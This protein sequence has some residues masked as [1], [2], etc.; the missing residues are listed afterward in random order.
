MPIILGSNIASLQAQRRLNQSSETLARG[1]ERLG[2][3]MRINRASDDA[4]GLA[5]VS[6]LRT[7]SRIF[8]QAIRNINDGISLIA[9]AQGALTQLSSIIQ[10]Q[11]EL[12]EQAANG[13]YSSTQRLALDRESDALVDEYN[14]I[15]KST[16][17][18]GQYILDGN[19]D[20][21]R[22]QHGTGIA[23]STQ[24][25]IGQSL[26]SIAGDG[27]F[28][29]VASF[30]T[31][32]SANLIGL[33]T[34]DVN[35]DGILDIVT[36]NVGADI[37]IFFGNGSGGFV[38]HTTFNESAGLGGYSI[39]LSDLNGDGHQ[40]IVTQG[41][42]SVI[43]YLG[44]GDGT[45]QG[46]I[47]SSGTNG[48]D[49]TISDINSDGK[50]DVISSGGS[51]SLGN[52]D[53]SFKAAYDLAFVASSEEI[54]VADLN[55]DGF[56]DLSVLNY[57]DNTVTNY[58]GRGD[59][60]FAAGR[61]IFAGTGPYGM[62]V[63]DLSGDGNI[64]LAISG[65]AGNSVKILLG[66]GDG[67][68][69]YGNTHTTNGATAITAGDFNGDGATDL[70]STQY[71]GGT[72]YLL[73]GN[74]DGSFKSPQLSSIGQW[75]Y[76]V[77]SN[78]INRDGIEDIIDWNFNS[79]LFN[80]ALGNP[81]P[82]GRR[83]NT[84]E[85]LDLRTTAGARAA[86]DST[87]SMLEKISLEISSLG[88]Q[89]SRLNTSLSMLTTKRENYIAAAGRISDADIAFESANLIRS[90]ILQKTAA[91]VFAQANKQPQIA[92]MLLS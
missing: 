78:D 25:A 11:K 23:E 89:E 48:N 74:G 7:D 26:G 8:T 49:L 6:T 38:S 34:G 57:G 21:V 5:I 28:G 24:I 81:D 86:L 41:F 10:R 19:N 31:T 59:G 16:S 69:R 63:G 29:A 3:G 47:F 14:R 67:S 52:G 66:N 72:L 18:N 32:N 2:S 4:A 46:S 64:D 39:T 87:T 15:I 9:I 51:I 37:E 76:Q 35:N 70:A 65:Y 82:S 84:M 43:S 77:L 68:F 58:L 80:V 13:T 56:A 88:A 92:L 45:F 27:T 71:P 55:N 22:L 54:Y 36:Q 1:L 40:D 53:G 12:A 50:L 30:D 75:G 60:T 33:T 42:G 83:N 44:N 17:F 79:S 91:A 85:K 73:F 90:Q 61:S 62:V 20:N